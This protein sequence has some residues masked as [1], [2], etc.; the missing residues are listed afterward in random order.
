MGSVTSR[1]GLSSLFPRCP[2]NKNR[3]LANDENL[4]N[5]SRRSRSLSCPGKPGAG[6]RSLSGP[7][8]K[9]DAGGGPRARAKPNGVAAYPQPELGDEGSLSALGSAG[10]RGE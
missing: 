1:T 3:V 6:A 9:Q 5:R 2:K 8:K 4:S 7:S 10:N